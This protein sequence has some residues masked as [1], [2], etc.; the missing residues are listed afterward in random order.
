MSSM[1]NN[2]TSSDYQKL[3]EELANLQLVD[4]EDYLSDFD[5]DDELYLSE[6]DFDSDDDD[7]PTTPFPVQ[8]ACGKQVPPPPNKSTDSNG[9]QVTSCKRVLDFTNF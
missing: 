9:N 5:S 8:K 7:T 3:L 6:S 4:L 1:N 2:T